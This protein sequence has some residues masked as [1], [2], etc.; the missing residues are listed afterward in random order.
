MASSV[1]LVGA[2]F[3]DQSL[4]QG[5]NL[6]QEQQKGAMRRQMRHYLSVNRL[7][8][9]DRTC[10]SQVCIIWMDKDTSKV[11]SLFNQPNSW[12]VLITL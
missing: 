12:R 6:A 8:V 4:A 5:P 3:D 1:P 7:S 2:L 9:P 10:I 11:H